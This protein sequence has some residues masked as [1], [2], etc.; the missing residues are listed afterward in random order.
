MRSIQ[1]AGFTLIEMS[2]ALS[3][4]GVALASAAMVSNTGSS[5]HRATASIQRLEQ[6]LHRAL[7]RAAWEL[8]ATGGDHLE[9]NPVDGLAYDDLEFQAVIGFT[10]TNPDLGPTSQLVAELEAG[11]VQDGIDN[12]GDGLVDERNLVLVRDV[13]GPNEQRVVICHG[14]LEFLEGETFDGT[15]ENGN[16]LE[17]EPGFHLERNGNVITIR[18]SLGSQDPDGR[19]FVRTA[20]LDT[21]MRN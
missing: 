4:L 13:D 17:D 3:C 8:A 7:E 2:I 21:R 1:R 9:P 18:L 19:V 5:A 15:D 10:G 11:E 20:E 16:G 14:V 6:N 12:D